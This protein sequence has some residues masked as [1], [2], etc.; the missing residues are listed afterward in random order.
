MDHYIWIHLFNIQDFKLNRELN[1]PNGMH[2]TSYAGNF[3]IFPSD[4]YHGVKPHK[5]R[6]PRISISMNLKLI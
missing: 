6:S 2:I 1:T 4:L 5:F 3:I